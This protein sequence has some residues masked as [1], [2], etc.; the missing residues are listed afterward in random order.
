MNGNPQRWLVATALAAAVLMLAGA[1]LAASGPHRAP[2]TFAEGTPEETL[3]RYVDAVLGGD[4]AA[5]RGTFA[6]R[7]AAACTGAAFDRTLDAVLEREDGDVTATDHRMRIIERGVMSDT[8]VRLR[9]RDT[10]LEVEPP[11]GVSRWTTD[12]VVAVRRVDDAWR[13]EATDW[14]EACP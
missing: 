5:A 14:P 12:H 11:F 1:L 13:L 2:E 9:V 4:A 8:A 6:P 3:Q 7:L 10:H